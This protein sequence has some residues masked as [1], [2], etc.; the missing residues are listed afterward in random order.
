M[1]ELEDRPSLAISIIARNEA[2]TIARVIES[3]HELAKLATLEGGFSRSRV[4]VVD[5][6]STDATREI[7]ERYG[8]EIIVLSHDN[9][10]SPAAARFAGLA[11]IEED[12]V[13]FVD[14][15]FVL[16]PSWISK[17]SEWLHESDIGGITGWLEEAQ[18]FSIPDFATPDPRATVPVPIDLA[19]LALFNT[20]IIRSVGGIEPYLVGAEDRD[21]GYR[22]RSKGFR[23]IE[24]PVPLGSHYWSPDTESINLV[25]YLRSVLRWSIGDGQLWRLRKD[26]RIRKGQCSRYFTLGNLLNLATPISIVAGVCGTALGLLMAAYVVVVPSILASALFWH[27]ASPRKKPFGGAR[28]LTPNLLYSTVRLGGFFFGASQRTPPA[29]RFRLHPPATKVYGGGNTVSQARRKWNHD[30]R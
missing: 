23:I 24:L 4:Q 15:D 1:T 9:R 2:D 11:F 26:P 22:L 28:N 5:S 21:L 27:L 13:L 29:S 20:Q 8:V 30:L 7:A 18:P 3:A 16:N 6:G 12:W 10:L 25:T 14:G 19:P 17:A